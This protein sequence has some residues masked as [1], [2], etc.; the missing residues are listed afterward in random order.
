VGL[1]SQLVRPCLFHEASI[2]PVGPL[3]G[4]P[5]PEVLLLP[6]R[7]LTEGKKKGANILTQQPV[8]DAGSH[9]CLHHPPK[10]GPATGLWAAVTASFP[11]YSDSTDRSVSVLVFISFA[12]LSMRC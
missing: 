10:A 2:A 5:Q 3:A 6:Q 12:P 8:E 7:A 4:H 9:L 11:F 1:W